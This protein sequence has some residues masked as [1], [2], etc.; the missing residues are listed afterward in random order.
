MLH[1]LPV[2]IARLDERGFTLLH[3]DRDYDP[4][5]M[6]LGLRVAR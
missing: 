2:L 6:H 4:F 1:A 3:S 5:E